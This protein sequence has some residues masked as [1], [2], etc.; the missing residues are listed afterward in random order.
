[1]ARLREGACRKRP[2]TER[3]RRQSPKEPL[4]LSIGRDPHGHN[5]SENAPNANK[6]CTPGG[7]APQ[8]RGLH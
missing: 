3:K 6:M 5:F 7:A 2:V 8:Q 4:Q 1:M